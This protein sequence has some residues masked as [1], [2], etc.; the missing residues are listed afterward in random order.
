MPT[1]FFCRVCAVN[2][3]LKIIILTL[4][5]SII[6]K[7]S[8]LTNFF[9]YNKDIDNLFII[10]CLKHKIF[11]LYIKNI[12]YFLNKF[13]NQIFYFFLQ[14][15]KNYNN[16]NIALSLVMFDFVIFLVSRPLSGF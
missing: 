2:G 13:L 8:D 11:E 3:P 1:S 12:Q 10:Q 15:I 14:I 6:I 9:I 4:K 16:Y 7:N 5:T